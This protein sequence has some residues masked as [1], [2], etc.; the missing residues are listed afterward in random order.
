[1]LPHKQVQFRTFTELYSF[2][3]TP[4]QHVVFLDRSSP[5]RR[6]LEAPPEPVLQRLQVGIHHGCDV[7][8]QELKS[9][10]PTTATPRG[11]RDSEP[12]PMPRAMGSVPISAAMV[13]IMMGR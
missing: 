12:A 3:R 4:D 9:R 13:V 2:V 10:P 1:M 11:R 6:L 5:R 8:S 7:K